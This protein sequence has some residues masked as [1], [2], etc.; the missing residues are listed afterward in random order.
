LDRW[1]WCRSK[2]LIR[3]SRGSKAHL[4]HLLSLKA[5][6]LLQLHHCGL[7]TFA[8]IPLHEQPLLKLVMI[9][10]QLV[11]TLFQPLEPFKA[12]SLQQLELFKACLVRCL[13]PLL[14]L[15]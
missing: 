9:L 2:T 10:L 14:Q 1:R 11:M 6:L 4:V 8:C 12:T 5:R 15:I 3:R 13:G 7:E